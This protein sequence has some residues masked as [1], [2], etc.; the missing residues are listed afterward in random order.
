MFFATTPHI[1]LEH[2]SP[3]HPSRQ[4][5]HP[6]THIWSLH[7]G[8]TC[9]FTHHFLP[10]NTIH[11][12]TEYIKSSINTAP[13][14]LPRNPKNFNIYFES[15]LNIVHGVYLFFNCGQIIWIVAHNVLV[16]PRECTVKCFLMNYHCERYYLRMIFLTRYYLVGLTYYILSNNFFGF[17]FIRRILFRFIY[18]YRYL[19]I[20]CWIYFTIRLYHPRSID[21]I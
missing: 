9:H 5:F 13:P 16:S 2:L 21:A 19:S 8:I 12:Y 20:I 10:S 11:I 4:Y 6:R 1:T 17:L 18:W 3:H 7:L 15:T 14:P